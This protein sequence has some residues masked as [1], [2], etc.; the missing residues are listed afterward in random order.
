LSY[1]AACWSVGE[2]TLHSCWLY[3]SHCWYRQWYFACKK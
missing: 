1:E 2:L 3:L